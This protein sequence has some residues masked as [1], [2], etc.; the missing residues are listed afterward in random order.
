[1]LSSLHSEVT[2]ARCSIL[3]FELWTISKN[4]EHVQ[5]LKI[6]QKFELFCFEQF[7][8][9]TVQCL[10]YFELFLFWT[11]SKFELFWTMNYF[12]LFFWTV[13]CLNYF[14]LFSLQKVQLLN[15]FLNSSIM[16]YFVWMF[17]ELFCKV[18]Y[19][20]GLSLLVYGLGRGLKLMSLG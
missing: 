10:N 3:F 17:T 9:W 12:E 15:Y 5:K 20:L 14:E 11:C 1:M 7:N 18:N 16:N 19:D 2:S 4:F 13:Q 6:V 8:F